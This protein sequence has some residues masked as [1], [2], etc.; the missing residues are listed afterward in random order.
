MMLLERLDPRLSLLFPLAFFSPL[1]SPSPQVFFEPQLPH[2]CVQIKSK[3][4]LY[5]LVLMSYC[6]AMH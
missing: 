6:V 3:T 1:V 2:T 4:L 5:T